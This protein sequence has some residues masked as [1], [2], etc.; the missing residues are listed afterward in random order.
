MAI[1]IEGDSGKMGFVAF[2]S[3]G[4]FNRTKLCLAASSDDACEEAEFIVSNGILVYL[5][6]II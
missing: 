5:H 3:T 4:F 6:E 1:F 2:G